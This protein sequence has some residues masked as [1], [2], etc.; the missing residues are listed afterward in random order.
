MANDPKAEMVAAQTAILQTR[1]KELGVILDYLDRERVE[2]S[3]TN[4]MVDDTLERRCQ[5]AK[6][7]AG[8][9]HAIENWG[10]GRS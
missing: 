9:D 10:G 4:P 5:I 8:L 6:Q 7:I 2:S 3:K 1:R